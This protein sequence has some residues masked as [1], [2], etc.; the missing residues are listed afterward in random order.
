MKIQK[1]ILRVE[2]LFQIS[3]SIA[4]PKSGFK[5]EIQISQSNVPHLCFPELYRFLI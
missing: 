1:Q 3:R 5:I 4:N 2:I